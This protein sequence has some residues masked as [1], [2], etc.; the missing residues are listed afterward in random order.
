MLTPVTPPGDFPIDYTA[1]LMRDV[2]ADYLRQVQGAAAR[3][4]AAGKCQGDCGIRTAAE[5]EVN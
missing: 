5:R 3:G 4:S 2:F 1:P